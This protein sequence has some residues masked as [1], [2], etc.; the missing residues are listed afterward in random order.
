MAA[1]E[2]ERLVKT[3]TVTR[4]KPGIR[5]ALQA[6][7]APDRHEVR[8]V[9]DIS[10]TVERGEILGYIGPNG[11]GKSTTVKVLAGILTP[12][13][14]RATVGGI[15]PYEDPQANARQIGSVF[16]QRSRLWWTLPCYDSCEYTRALYSIEAG[17]YRKNLAYFSERLAL[18]P[19]MDR[20]VRT[21]SLGERMRVE[22]AVAM[23]HDPQILFLDEPTVGLDVVAKGELRD[24]IQALNRDR[25]VTIL[26][27]THD[28]IDIE[29]LS[30]RAVIMDT[31]RL[32]WE[33][34]MRE[35]KDVHGRR[36][37]VTVEFAEPV[38]ALSAAGVELIENQGTRQRYAV[39]MASTSV[40][41][42]VAELSRRSQVID[43]TVAEPEIEQV[44][45]DMYGNAGLD[46]EIPHL[47]RGRLGRGLQDRARLPGQRLR[48]GQRS[49]VHGVPAGGV[50]ERP[51]PRAGAGRRHRSARHAAVRGRQ[52]AAGGALR[53]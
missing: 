42:V 47:P 9:D 8:A 22:L 40:D 15:V 6:L 43:L 38:A 1:I 23:L 37:I 18:G 29:K 44:I 12:T 13:S 30:S 25:G 27:V 46:E 34:T 20:Q 50:L 33:G 14:G 10:L 21:L 51:V 17:R 32:V 26:L 39:N 3:F 19:L 45:R 5:G 28:V 53:A 2:I 36:R 11:A 35:L 48:A 4:R 31:G 52:H 16:G 7:V 24:M 49:G 41:R